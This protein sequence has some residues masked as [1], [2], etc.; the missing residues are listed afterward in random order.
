M[1]DSGCT[2]EEPDLVP[3]KDRNME[4]SYV[5]GNPYSRYCRTCGRRYFCAKSYW[6]HAGEKF[7]IPVDDDEPVRLDEYDGDNHF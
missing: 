1:S 3:V 7:V 6:E 5:S 2:C 4:R